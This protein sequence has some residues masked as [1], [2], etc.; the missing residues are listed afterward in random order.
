MSRF[1]HPPQTTENEANFSGGR[2]AGLPLHQFQ[3]RLNCAR[4]TFYAYA[5]PF[6]VITN[7]LR[8]STVI[9][10]TEEGLYTQNVCANGEF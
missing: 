8:I 2:A 9:F 5:L 10:H 6:N 4:A 7:I 1:Q 3:I